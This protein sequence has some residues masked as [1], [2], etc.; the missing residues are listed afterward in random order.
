MKRIEIITALALVLGAGHVAMAGLDHELSAAPA[1]SAELSQLKKLAGKWQG[2]TKHGNGAEEPA[3]AEYKVTSGGSAVIETLFPGTPHEMVSVYHD[4]RGKPAM[5]HYCM[6]GNQPELELKS[7]SGEQF[8]FDLASSSSIPATEMHMH[9][10]AM[11]WN[12]PDH[13]TQ[14]WTSFKEG[15]PQESTTIQ[16]KRVN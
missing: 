4:K 2:T 8:D 13:V 12:G 7:A 6:L 5:T 3:A 9:S 10:L 15:Q 16:L 1:S 11:T 14:V